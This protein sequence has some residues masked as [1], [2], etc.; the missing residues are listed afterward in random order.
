L[1]KRKKILILTYYWPPSG[2][3]GVQRWLHFTRYLKELG[4][5]PIIFTP[6]NPE[7]PV[8][9]PSLLD[10]VP[11]DIH[12]IQQEIWE[13][14]QLYLK[15]TGNKGK[16][17]HTGFL[18]EKNGKKAGL[19][20]KIS[21]WLRANLFIPDAKMAWIKPATKYLSAFL[22]EQDVAAIISTGPPH[23]L[24]LIARNLKRKTQLPWIADFRDPWTQ[25]DWFEQLPLTT[26]A[27]RQHQKLEKSVFDEADELVVVSQDMQNQMEF[28]A[29]RRPVLISNG[30][31]PEDFHGFEKQA[32]PHFTI[33]HTGSINKDRN[34]SALWQSLG[35]YTIANPDFAAKLRI[36]LIGAVDACVHK[37]IQHFG[38]QDHTYFESFVPHEQVIQELSSCSLLLLP[39]NNVKSQK[40]IVTGKVFEYLASQQAILAIGPADGDAAAILNS[41]QGTFRVD[42]GAA[43]PWAEV[44]QMC[45]HAI[46]RK[47]SLLPYSRQELAKEMHGLLLKVS[48]DE[49]D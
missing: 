3:T 29:K 40:G 18:Q 22:E 4:W 15:F 16:Q 39:L 11:K 28:L 21:L 37:D 41:Q 10:Y 43:V 7:A 47:E 2:G 14:T 34:P 33:L 38:L 17:L 8:Q 23:S 5:D 26:W 36:R 6:S 9:D 48:Q 24:H 31:A 35:A 32:D 13:P 49:K 20:K 27:L 19:S 12:I 44:L 30:F 45:Q 1:A 42:F 46:V 25:I